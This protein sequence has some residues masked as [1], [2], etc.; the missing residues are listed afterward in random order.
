MAIV[1]Y[2]KKKLKEMDN[3]TLLMAYSN[4]IA[5]YNPAQEWNEECNKIESELLSR[6][7]NNK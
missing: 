5:N 1:T 7:E 3:E 4:L 2:S 6:M